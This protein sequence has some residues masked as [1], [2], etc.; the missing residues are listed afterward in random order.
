VGVQGFSAGT[1]QVT[2]FY[3]D[4]ELKGIAA[5]TLFM[6]YRPSGAPRW[7]KADNQGVFPNAQ[8]ARG[9]IGVSTLNASPVIG[10]AS[11]PP[12]TV[13]VAGVQDASMFSR[14]PGY[15]PVLVI[16]LVLVGPS[17]IVLIL[18]RRRS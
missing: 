3:R 7:V 2:T 16:L 11:E 5:N 9:D 1:A 12:R 4:D 10:L 14:I 15:W 13:E 6:T 8:N 17:S 18:T